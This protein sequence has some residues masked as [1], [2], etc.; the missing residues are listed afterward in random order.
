MALGQDILTVTLNPAL[1]LAARVPAMVA[2]PKLRLSRPITEPGGGGVNVA[3]A[4]HAL[5]GSVD[6]W[7]ALGGTS[8]A[9]LA[10]LLTEGGLTVHGFAAPGETRTNWAITDAAGAQYRLQ[11]PGPD[12][13]DALG[14]AA[15]QDICKQAA[16][17]VVLSG[18]LPHGL[19]AAFPCHLLNALG[20]GRLLLDTSG[21]ALD[22]VVRQPNPDLLVL[23]MDAEEAEGLGCDPLFD[24][25]AALG[26]AQ[27]L[28]TRGVA[29]WVSVA[30]GA[31][32]N[33]IAGPMGV[34]H[35]CRP[36]IVP[37][38]SPVGAG[39]SFMGA[40]ALAIAQGRA[41]SDALRQGTAAAAA[42]VMSP[43]S[44]LCRA[45]D[46]AR[47]VPQCVLDS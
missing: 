31:Q 30:C 23:R 34:G 25:G 15:I 10:A 13:P 43:G 14:A 7:V 28:Q 17:L 42:A 41:M 11:M 26:F 27:T 46:V 37:V 32:G 36:P 24:L 3:R 4:I 40:F 20:A 44:A 1:D 18:S 16:G 29:Q 33:V 47:L 9:Q 12:W 45:E 22:W 5:G 8:G 39:D 19:P 2:G 35:T 21:T 6:A 38:D